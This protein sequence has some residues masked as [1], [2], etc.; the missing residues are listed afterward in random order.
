MAASKIEHE[1]DLSLI[2]LILNKKVGQGFLSLPC[3]LSCK[4]ASIIKFIIN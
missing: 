1:L 3:P 2:F 4:V